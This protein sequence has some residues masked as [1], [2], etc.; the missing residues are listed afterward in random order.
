MTR[1]GSSRLRVA[2]SDLVDP[3]HISSICFEMAGHKNSWTRRRNSAG[4]LA[5]ND[6]ALGRG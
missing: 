3:N 1:P 6:G 4:L 2:L 5:E